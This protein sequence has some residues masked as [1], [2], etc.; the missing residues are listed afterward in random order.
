MC[1]LLGLFLHW[2][3]QLHAQSSPSFPCPAARCPHGPAPWC[4]RPSADGHLSGLQLAACRCVYT[5]VPRGTYRALPQAEYCGLARYLEDK[6]SSGEHK[7]FSLIFT[8]TLGPARLLNVQPSQ[9]CVASLLLS[10]F[11][12]HFLEFSKAEHLSLY[13]A[14]EFPF[15]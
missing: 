8:L 6:A 14:Q 3:I 1:N 12:R 9:R 7:R 4:A 13:S 15:L 2:F 11:W 5:G 10:W